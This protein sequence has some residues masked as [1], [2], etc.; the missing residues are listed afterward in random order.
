MAW[1][2]QSRT[3]SGAIS[4]QVVF[5]K[6]GGRTEMSH[7][8]S[9]H[10]DAELAALRLRAQKLMSPGQLAL[11]FGADAAP[12]APR[13][14]SS[15]AVRLWEALS[16]AYRRLGFEAAVGDDA[17][18]ALVLARVIEPASK[19]DTL[20]VLAELGLRPPSYATVQRALDRCMGRGYREACQAACGEH[21]GAEGLRL[22]LYDVTTLYFETDKADGFRVPG[23]SKE[24][25]LEPQITVGLLTDRGGFPLMVRAFE[26]DRAETKTL[27]PVMDEF[28]AANP[29]AEV[30]LVA[31]AGMISEANMAALEDAGWRFIVGGRLAAEPPPV[32]VWRAARPGQEL[33]DGQFFSQ[34]RQ[35]SRRWIEW[36]RYS[37]KAAKRNLHGIDES[38]RK[39]QKI[40]DGKGS[41][42][43]NRFLK[44]SAATPEIDEGLVASARAR[45]GLRSYVTNLEADPEFIAH[46]YHQLYHIEA[47][48]RMSKHDLEARPAYHYKRERIEAHLTIV[49]AALA[50]GKW[51]EARADLSLRA[52]LNAVRPIREITIEV[53]GTPITAETEVGEDAHRALAAIHGATGEGD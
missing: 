30:T 50:V 3:A 14:V 19:R 47:A 23:Y 21:V 12:G 34:T 41:A 20:R 35:G 43:R 4:V 24:R 22:C 37:R 17:F 48:F 7:V 13:V 6:A 32:A 31:D 44:A 10:N 25:R 49:F 46:A 27:L 52:F 45:A 29:T 16:E 28:R 51:I 11:D 38:L 5:S 39:A 53:A 8:G 40:I 15:R 26:G 36:I 9:A 1:I 18:R 2:K 33:A 42:K